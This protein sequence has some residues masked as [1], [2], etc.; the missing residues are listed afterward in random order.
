M[1]KQ[2]LEKEQKKSSTHL[3]RNPPEHSSSQSSEVSAERVFA[4]AEIKC[5]QQWT[6]KLG[7][8]IYRSSNACLQVDGLERGLVPGKVVLDVEVLY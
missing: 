2:W 6:A 5:I 8:S 3:F 7:K 4:S 1:K